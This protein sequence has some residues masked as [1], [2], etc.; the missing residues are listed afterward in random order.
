M[1]SRLGES[2]S[3]LYRGKVTKT[4][5][6]QSCIQYL[7]NMDFVANRDINVSLASCLDHSQKFI[8]GAFNSIAAR[9]S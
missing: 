2:V 8:R 9:S 3:D 6:I 7:P 5:Q 1:N 4:G